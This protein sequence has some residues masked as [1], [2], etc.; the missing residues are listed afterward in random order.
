MM[1]M[2]LTMMTTTTTTVAVFTLSIWTDG[3]KQTVNTQIRRGV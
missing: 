3:P 1:M 2:I